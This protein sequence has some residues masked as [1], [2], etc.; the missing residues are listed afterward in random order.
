MLTVTE[1]ALSLRGVCRAWEDGKRL[2][3]DPG[4][5]PKR[6]HWEG[7]MVSMGVT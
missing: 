5:H 2:P 7:G 4:G 3:L 1:A 6:G